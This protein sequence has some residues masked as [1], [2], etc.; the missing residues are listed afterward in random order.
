LGGGQDE[1]GGTTFELVQGSSWSEQ[2]LT[3]ATRNPSDSPLVVN[4]RMYLTTQ[5]GG[6][7]WGTLTTGSYSNNQLVI[8]GSYSFTAED[9]GAN[10]VSRLVAD[11]DGNLYGTTS[12]GGS[13]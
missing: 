13:L 5:R 7:S 1:Y 8:E 3:C 4:N 10:P 2:Q 6:L 11:A 9:D 12:G